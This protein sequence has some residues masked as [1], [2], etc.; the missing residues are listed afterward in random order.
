MEIRET[1]TG[2]RDRVLKVN[3]S[4]NIG[5]GIVAGANNYVLIVDEGA[6]IGHYSPPVPQDY[7]LVIDE[8][9]EIHEGEFGQVADYVLIVNETNVLKIP[10]D[11]V[12]VVNEGLTT[13]ESLVFRKRKKYV[14]PTPGETNYRQPSPNMKPHALEIFPKDKEENEV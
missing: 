9:N 7:I 8:S 3:E 4:A 13:N 11:Y 5:H 12:L 1:I 2:P 10:I 14:P 6:N